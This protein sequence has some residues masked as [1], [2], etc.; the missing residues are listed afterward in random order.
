[1]GE[2]LGQASAGYHG[3][4][5][6]AALGAIIGASIGDGFGVLLPHKWD[7]PILSLPLLSGPASSAAPMDRLELPV[8]EAPR[9]S[10]LKPASPILPAQLS[11]G[12]ISHASQLRITKYAFTSTQI[13]RQTSKRK[14]R[15]PYRTGWSQVLG[16]LWL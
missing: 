16:L 14:L 2:L 7:Y 10:H 1:M 5:W 15:H 12:G 13:I 9:A 6:K 3:N 4:M 8:E 11:Q